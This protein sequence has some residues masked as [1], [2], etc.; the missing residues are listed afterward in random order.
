MSD[1]ERLIIIKTLAACSFSRAQAAAQLGVTRS[2]FWRRLKYLHIDLG[3][4]PRT[5]A[6]RSRKL[7]QAGVV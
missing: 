5:T 6:G 7:K 4:M 2:Y 3:A 1:Y